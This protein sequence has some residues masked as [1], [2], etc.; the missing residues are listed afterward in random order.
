MDEREK[1]KL[2]RYPVPCFRLGR[3]AADASQ[4]DKGV[5]RALIGCAVQR[6]LEAR[7][8]V[9]A[10]ALLVDAKDDEAKSFY[11]HFGFIAC[12]DNPKSLYLPL[13]VKA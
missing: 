6:C 12:R 8:L 9:A 2:P 4:R 3:L 13:G 11:E 5:G 1:Q 10:Y 7:E